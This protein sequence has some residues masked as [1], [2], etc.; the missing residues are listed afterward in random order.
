MTGAWS[1]ATE[2]AVPGPIIGRTVGSVVAGVPARRIGWV[3]RAGVPLRQ[4]G[5]GRWQCP[6]TAEL[7]A[8]AGGGLQPVTERA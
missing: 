7:Y 6:E 3:G 2:R 1:S 4:A 8:E 5:A